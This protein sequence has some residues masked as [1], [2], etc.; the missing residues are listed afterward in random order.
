MCVLKDA[1][2]SKLSWL[3]ATIGPIQQLDGVQDR[4]LRA[5]GNLRHAADIAGC[6][7]IGLVAS[8]FLIFRAFSWPD[9][10]GCMML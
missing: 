3:F 7:D 4:H 9:I 2:R 8:M 5:R 10:S 1:R 6:D